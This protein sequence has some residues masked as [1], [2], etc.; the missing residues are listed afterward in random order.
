MVLV[1]TVCV[2]ICMSMYVNGNTYR[3]IKHNPDFQ[4][5]LTE[6]QNMNVA[7]RPSLGDSVNGHHCTAHR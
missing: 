2:F 5:A 6:G 3:K 7:I 1:L 4:R